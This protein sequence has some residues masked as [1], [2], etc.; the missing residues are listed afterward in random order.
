MVGAFLQHL[1]TERGNTAT[2]RNA[3]LAA[4]H[5]F[6]RHALPRAPEHA[7]LI[8]R[9]LAIPPKRVDRAIVDYLTRTET[10]ALIAA[11]DTS[12]WTG[13]RDNA[14]ILVAVH[15]GLRVTELANLRI[16]DTHLAAGAHLRCH[17][18]GRK[19]RC[20][21]LTSV[22]A[23][24]LRTWLKERGGQPDDPLFP[25]RRGTLL[26]RD[27]IARLVAKHAKAAE[28]ACPSLTSKNVTPHTLRHSYGTALAEAGV[29]LAVM[30][31]LL[32]HAH[33]DTTARYIHLA[34]AH[35]KAEFDAARD[36]LRSQS[37]Q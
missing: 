4:I 26:S 32:G 12:T 15:T 7:A 31:A 35:V 9:V 5:S 3:R 14:L 11:P 27:A 16:R 24:V 17:G 1:E 8:Q 34:P 36:R 13:R 25:T 19:D 23:K 30:Q 20:T 33:V 29:D 21:P 2:T 37:Q 18:K 28:A 10:D 6:F 22:T